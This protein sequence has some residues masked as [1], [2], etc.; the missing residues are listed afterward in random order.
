MAQPGVL[1]MNSDITTSDTVRILDNATTYWD[2]AKSPITNHPATGPRTA[3][4]MWPKLFPGNRAASP[5]SRRATR[6]EPRV[7]TMDEIH[8]SCRAS[9]TITAGRSTSMAEARMTATTSMS[10]RALILS[11]TSDPPAW[12]P[13]WGPGAPASVPATLCR[14]A[15]KAV[16][17]AGPP[18]GDHHFPQKPPH[19]P[20]R[21]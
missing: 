4:P 3:F 6:Q 11:V 17:W 19:V 10:C 5:D 2:S 12:E 13:S 15:P 8:E 9:P 14:D 18:T 20:R 16:S 1:G 21:E 7:E